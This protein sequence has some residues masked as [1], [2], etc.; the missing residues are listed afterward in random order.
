MNPAL[1]LNFG[2]SFESEELK[3]QIRIEKVKELSAAYDH[4]VKTLSDIP[5]EQLSKEAGYIHYF[6]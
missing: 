2:M 1:S 6:S 4:I 5:K 3:R